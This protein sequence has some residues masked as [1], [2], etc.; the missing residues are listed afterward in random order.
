MIVCF[1]GVVGA[2]VDAHDD[3]DVLVRRRGGDDDL[4]RAG[5]DVL[6]RVGR[7]GEEAGRLD[8][9]VH[10][11][12]APRQLRRVTLGEDLDRG[13]A[14]RD[15]VV[16]D[17]DVRRIATEDRVVL[18]QMRHRLHVAEVVRGDE[19]DVGTCGVE[20]AVEVAADPAEAVD[21]DTYGHSG[22]TPRKD[23][24]VTPKPYPVGQARRRPVNYLRVAATTR[25]AT[26]SGWD[27]N[28]ECEDVIV[29]TVPACADMACCAA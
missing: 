16:G 2:V 27:R 29:S 8:D 22:S 15:P 26:A 18:E 25:S 6:A 17:R 4:L 24:S 1:D 12:L 13:A 19:L 3:R 28:G 5:I 11:E 9:D 10:A 21:A 20:G 7:L 14:D 23:A